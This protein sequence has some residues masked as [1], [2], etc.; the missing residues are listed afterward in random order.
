MKMSTFIKKYTIK[1]IEQMIGEAGKDVP[2]AV[3][4]KA[5][6]YWYYDNVVK[7]PKTPVPEKDPIDIVFKE[8]ILFRIDAH[9]WWG[10][11]TR[12]DES[13]IKAPKEIMKGIKTLIEESKLSAMQSLRSYGER[14]VKSRAY[15]F[16][17]L[18][19]V[20]YVPKAF[21]KNVEKELREVQ[22]TF[23]KR[24][25]KFIENY[26]KYK[27]AW[28]EKA[29]QYYDE[30]LY[31][32]ES[33]LRNKFKFDWTKFIITLPDS[34]MMVLNDEQIE[35][36][37]KKQRENMKRFM[38]ESLTVLASK[39]VKLLT[40]LNTRLVNGEVMRQKSI[41]SIQTFIE[42]FDAWNFTSNKELKKMVSEARSIM[43]NVNAKGLNKDEKLSK[44]IERETKKVLQSFESSAKTD[45]RFLRAL[46]F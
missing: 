6:V 24:V 41:K 14:I 10:K 34:N 16:L 37:M 9:C 19:G 26:P 22:S 45:E 8:G 28:K 17:G 21:I 5:L 43:K 23:Y 39:F 3:S 30:K 18:R 42:T 35:E 36:E 31:P 13:E 27:E 32:T 33:S 44:R 12:V 20:Y 1:Q 11:S 15:P 38:D 4:K 29:K 25:E 7:A 2:N 40:N 46:D